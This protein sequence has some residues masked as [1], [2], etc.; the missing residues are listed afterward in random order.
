MPL[1][2]DNVKDNKR[3]PN[4]LDTEDKTK[5]IHKMATTEDYFIH[6]QAHGGTRRL[7]FCVRILLADTTRGCCGQH[8]ATSLYHISHFMLS[9]L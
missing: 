8:H 9:Y 7:R 4:I 6:A 3:H 5:R 1:Y 2:E